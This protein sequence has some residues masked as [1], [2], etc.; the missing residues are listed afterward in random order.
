MMAA[1]GIAVGSL[2]CLSARPTFM[3]PAPQVAAQR[4]LRERS[5][6]ARPS[7]KATVQRRISARRRPGN[8]TDAA[9]VVLRVVEKPRGVVSPSPRSSV[10]SMETPSYALVGVLSA[11]AIGFVYG[12]QL[13]N[14]LVF[15]LFCAL[16]VVLF[17]D[18]LIRFTSRLTEALNSLHLWALQWVGI[19]L[20]LIA[21]AHPQYVAMPHRTDLWIAGVNIWHWEEQP[22]DSFKH[23]VLAAL[24]AAGAGSW[25]A[26]PPTYANISLATFFGS[27]VAPSVAAGKLG[28][29]L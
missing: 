21:V 12:L 2:S 17:T 3:R 19:L 22:V 28:S 26:G 15:W 16:A 27:Q 1:G 29:L 25:I 18:W 6:R 8:T 13:G 9:V 14:Q 4:E 7:I 23:G 10:S 24:G 5:L 20:A 11:F